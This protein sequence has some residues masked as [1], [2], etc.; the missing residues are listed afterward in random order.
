[1]GPAL[2]SLESSH[3][4]YSMNAE[5]CYIPPCGQRTL[6]LSQFKILAWLSHSAPQAK[7]SHYVGLR[8][9]TASALVCWLHP[10]LEPYHHAVRAQE[11][12]G[13]YT[14]ENYGV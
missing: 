14:E 7:H 10:L 11:T 12:Q 1:M 9:L 5:R 3:V 4:R 6:H 13:A 2:K 8:E